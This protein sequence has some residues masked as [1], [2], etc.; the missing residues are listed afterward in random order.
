MQTSTF[1][2]FKMTCE[3]TLN[4]THT[5]VFFIDITQ[6]TNTKTTSLWSDAASSENL[7]LLVLI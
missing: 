2:H 5:L 1:V 4:I 3:K 7:S 6:N